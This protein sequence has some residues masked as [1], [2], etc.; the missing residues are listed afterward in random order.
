MAASAAPPKWFLPVM[1]VIAVLIFT[2]LGVY[3]YLSNKSPTNQQN[4][5]A[6][7]T[8][9]ECA[10]GYCDGN[11]CADKPCVTQ[12]LPC[13]D[14]SNCCTQSCGTNGLCAAGDTFQAVS[15]GY[16]ITSSGTGQNTSDSPAAC[17]ATCTGD[18][19]GYTY[20]DNTGTCSITNSMRNPPIYTDGAT[21]YLKKKG[22]QTLVLPG[23]FIGSAQQPYS[24]KSVDECKN[25]CTGTCAGYSY[26]SSNG[27]CWLAT[28]LTLLSG[29]SQDVK[30]TSYIL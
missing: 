27:D 4:G 9:K 25:M 29:E 10:S 2:G 18:C 30:I 16:N 12:G 8:A 5:A 6:C 22:G 17:E 24:N 3:A 23:T 1:I 11:A 28:D 19:I 21:S 7:I 26:D 13:T 15:G 20:F 14:N